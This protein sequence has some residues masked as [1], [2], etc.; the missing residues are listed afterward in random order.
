MIIGTFKDKANDCAETTE[1]KNNQLK[2]RLQM[3]VRICL[4]TL[5]MVDGFSQLTA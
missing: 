2:T 1:E 5:M 4:S 3:I